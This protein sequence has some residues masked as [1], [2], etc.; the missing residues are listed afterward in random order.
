MPSN[1]FIPGDQIA[2]WRL[3]H[4]MKVIVHRT[5]RMH[6]PPA[7]PQASPKTSPETLAIAV[8]PKDHFP[9]IPG[10]MTWSV[11]A[12]YST[13]SLRAIGGSIPQTAWIVN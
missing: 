7:F 5:E 13:L 8:V 11:A 9:A 12:G 2:P 4:Q 6:L 10:F 1:H 3:D